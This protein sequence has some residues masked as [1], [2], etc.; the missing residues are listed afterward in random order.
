V[1]IGA[2]VVLAAAAGAHSEVKPSFVEQRCVR[3]RPLDV[4]GVHRRIVTERREL[5]WR[6]EVA[7]GRSEKVRAS[8]QIVQE[9]SR[10][11]DRPH[12]LEGLSKRQG[13]PQ[14]VSNGRHVDLFAGAARQGHEHFLLYE[15]TRRIVRA[16]SAFGF[17]NDLF[18]LEHC[19]PKVLQPKSNDEVA[20][21]SPLTLP[22]RAP[23]QFDHCEVALHRCSV[24]GVQAIGANPRNDQV[25]EHRKADASLTQRRQDLF[26]VREEQSVG[27][28][29]QHTLILQ[30]ESVGVQQVGR[31]MERN[32]GL[33]GPW[34]AL[35]HQKTS[36][37]CSDNLVLFA[38]NCCDDVTKASC[39]RCFECGD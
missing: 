14:T 5:L 17:L 21:K 13:A 31:P 33:S 36:L 16:E 3:E 6:E 18:A 11:Q 12:P 22:N 15:L 38:L 24:F 35:D 26:D 37:R 19:Q 7:S 39:T 2:H 10:R 27:P 4:V 25:A 29:D 32:N 30:G 8:K 1:S 34:S 9:V 23:D 20:A 28:H